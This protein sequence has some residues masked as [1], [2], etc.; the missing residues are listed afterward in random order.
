MSH[1]P[2]K[3]K[4]RNNATDSSFLYCLSALPWPFFCMQDKNKSSK[5]PS[6]FRKPW[7]ATVWAQELLIWWSVDE[8]ERHRHESCSHQVCQEI[9]DK[10][11]SLPRK[12]WWADT[13]G[14]RISA[15]QGPPL[16]GKALELLVHL[17]LMLKTGVG[18]DTS[19]LDV[20]PHTAIMKRG[21][22]KDFPC[23]E[24]W[25]SDVPVCDEHVGKKEL[26]Q[27]TVLLLYGRRAN[28]RTG[29]GLVLFL[30]TSGGWLEGGKARQGKLW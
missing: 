1:W 15:F 18:V 20:F 13:Q 24:W 28:R 6:F 11:L 30:M 14:R 26:L 10:V 2:D 4:K 25:Q 27:N 29:S 17:L 3:H 12:L 23:S 7:K 19:V 22:P 16:Q 8:K 9:Q 21:L 5:P